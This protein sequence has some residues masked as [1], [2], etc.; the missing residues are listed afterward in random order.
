MISGFMSIDAYNNGVYKVGAMA[1][2]NAASQVS[3]AFSEAASKGD[4]V[5]NISM[6]VSNNYLI[7]SPD[8][9]SILKNYVIKDVDAQVCGVLGE[10]S[11]KLSF[12]QAVYSVDDE[13]N[14]KGVVAGCY[15]ENSEKTV[16]TAFYKIEFK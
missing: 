12:E 4:Y 13:I 15:K 5:D 6:L 8:G 11:S 1:F 7:E 9:L 3:F 16:H 10:F 2:E 14:K